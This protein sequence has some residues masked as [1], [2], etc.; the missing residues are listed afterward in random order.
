MTLNQLRV[1]QAGRVLSVAP[2]SP[3]ATLLA[4]L[5][6]L[7]GTR[8]LI[9]RFAPLG[10]PISIRFNG[11]EFSLRRQ[12]AREVVVQREGPER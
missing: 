6:L 11:Q 7:P 5:G 2:D 8:V 9:E 1:G 3:S 4:A 12:D 10:D